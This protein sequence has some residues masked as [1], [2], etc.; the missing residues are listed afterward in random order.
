MKK[1]EEKN[2]KF[3][4]TP[5]TL[6]SFRYALITLII[7]LILMVIIPKVLNYG[8]GTIN[9]P[10]DIQMSNI[11]YNTQFTIIVCAIIFIIVLYQKCKHISNLKQYF[12]FMI[13]ISN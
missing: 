1:K 13:K 8:P 6:I 9:T 12:F 11:S 7:T 5:S 2:N 10:F 4:N 3:I